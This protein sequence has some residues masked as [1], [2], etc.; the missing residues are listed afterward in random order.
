MVGPAGRRDDAFCDVTMRQSVNL[1]I[2]DSTL[3]HQFR[4][5]PRVDGRDGAIRFYAGHP[6][7]AP[8]GERIGVLCIF[9][10]APRDFSAEEERVLGELAACIEHELSASEEL[11]RA[12]AVQRGLLPKQFL[13]L[14]GFDVAGGCAAAPGVGGDFYDWYPVGEGAA[15]TLADVMGKGI[16]AAIIAATVRAVL[17]AV[18]RRGEI[19][20]AVEAAAVILE[21]DLDGAGTFVTL[22]HAS[23]DMHTGVL[24]Y[25][26]AGHGLTLIAGADGSASRLSTTSLPLGADVEE[27]WR[28][29]AVTLAPGDTLIS[30]SDGVLD[31]FDG[32]LASLDEVEAIARSSA[33]SQ[34]L[35][36][37]LLALAGTSAPDDVTAVVVRRRP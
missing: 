19:A 35:V 11:E 9:D 4:E 29:H 10:S 18:S 32:T 2:P 20:A 8:G 34:D 25:I 15:V 1:V 22:F 26:D 3:D 36:D 27:T 14:P 7:E 31:L 23:L 21:S 12:A 6:L 30:V 24:R 28:E 33:T 16:G 17:R 5:N 37:T 13:S